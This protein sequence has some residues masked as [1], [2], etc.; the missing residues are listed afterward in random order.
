MD[1]NEILT[2]IIRNSRLNVLE[3]NIDTTN[4]LDYRNRVFDFYIVSF[5]KTGSCR[6]RIFD[7]DYYIKPGEAI[8]IPPNIAHDHVK[9]NNDLTQ[10]MWWHFNYKISGI[11]NLLEIFQLPIHFRILNIEKFEKYF[12]EYIESAK[13]VKD[14]AGFIEKEANALR[15]ISI[16]L[17]SALKYQGFK[18]SNEYTDVF[19]Q[20]LAE[21]VDRPEKQNSLEQLG[22]KHNLHPTYLSNRFKKIYGITPIKLQK[23]VRLRKAKLL[24][25]SE[26]LPISKIAEL[27]GYSDV[28]DFSRFFK[29]RQGVSP[30]SYKSQY[31]TENIVK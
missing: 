9:D 16:I 4:K 29:G 3:Y 10:F 19:L 22:K 14:I 7:K 11:I 6:L 27:V 21:I 20:I 25:Q 30:S 15:L 2:K 26:N 17:D 8:L 23:E 5:I 18:I 24:L 12:E 13:S 1:F 28:D 31:R